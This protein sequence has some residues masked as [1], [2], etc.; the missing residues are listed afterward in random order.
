MKYF[1]KVLLSIVPVF[2]MISSSYAQSGELCQ[3]HYY[4]EQEGAEKMRSLTH[5][6]NTAKDWD[7]HADSIRATL[8]K[9]MGLDVMPKRTPL[10]PKYRNKKV[11]NGYTV[12]SVIFE[13]LPGFF[14]TGN[15]YKPAG[16]LKKKSLAVILSPHGHFPDEQDY[17]RFRKDMQIRCAALAR[18]GAVVLA[19]DMVGWGESVQV[20]HNDSSVLLY[21]T[22]NSIRAIDFLLTLPEADPERVAVTGASGGGTQTF[23]LAAL[24]DRVKVSVPVV[25][26]SAH[27]F[28]GCVCE[29]GMP[30]HKNG[31]V[32]YTNAEIAC[33]V[34][35]KPMLW[36]SDGNDWTRNNQTVEYPFASHVYKLYD[37]ESMVEHV[38]LENE[39][40]DYGINKRTPV[41][42]F[43]A[44]HLRLD[45]SKIQDGSGNITEEFVML[46]DRKGLSYFTEQELKRIPKQNVDRLMMKAKEGK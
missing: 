9:G 31:D 40:H 43:L 46:L 6:L 1:V 44:K 36:V 22:W 33:V 8:R 39:G 28:G 41:Y 13:S 18:M 21:Q 11:L 15:L 3:G 38:H 26:V 42:A 5:R 35:P 2:F 16:K 25:M 23:M 32:V 10:N 30:V 20:S 12:E 29:S 7:D 37:K 19:Y 17:A 27:F 45:L 24:D 34:A 4:T 14:V